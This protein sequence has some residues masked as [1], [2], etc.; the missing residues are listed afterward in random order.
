V[1]VYALVTERRYNLR[2]M[3]PIEAFA[4]NPFFGLCVALVLVVIGT[5][6][7]TQGEQVVLLIA[8]C[9]FVLSVFRAY[10]ISKQVLGPRILLTLLISSVVGLGLFSIIGWRPLLSKFPLNSFAIINDGDYPVGTNLGNIAWSTRFSDLRVV[11]INET[12]FDYRDVDLTLQS[13]VPIAAIGQISSLP[14]VSFSPVADPTF[15]IS[16]I[17]GATNKQRVIPLILVASDSGYRVRCGLLPHNR[18]LEIVIAAGEIIDF[19]K[20]VAAPN[21]GAVLQRD[22]VLRLG[23][24]DSKTKKDIGNWYGYGADAKG[25]IEDIF[26]ENKPIPKVIQINGSYKV[27]GE[28]ETISQTIDAKD[29][30]GDFLKQ[31]IEP[32]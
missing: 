30:I 15:S 25:R 6:L 4:A 7:S 29:F 28:E 1:Q 12:D 14:D 19:P 13:D 5:K 9:L 32:R 10:P 31:K 27:N 17:D 22:Y 8:W 23:M 3:R 24:K 21:P 16:L 18:K 11:V 20:S 2:I 26:K